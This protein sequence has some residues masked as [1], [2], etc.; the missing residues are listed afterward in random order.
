MPLNGRTQQVLLVVGSHGT[1]R[2]MSTRYLRPVHDRNERAYIDLAMNQCDVHAQC[3]QTAT[4]F[5][6]VH[7]KSSRMKPLS[8]A[9]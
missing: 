9:T 6:T 4:A 3:P 2:S 1:Q 5:G 7:I 8:L